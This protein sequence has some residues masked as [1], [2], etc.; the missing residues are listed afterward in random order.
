MEVL[1]GM[2]AADGSQSDFFHHI[3][4]LAG[5]ENNWI[6]H[7]I[8][9]N[10][11][12]PRHR[13]YNM[14]NE[15]DVTWVNTTTTGS[16]AS[17]DDDTGWCLCHLEYDFSTKVMKTEFINL[18]TGHSTGQET[19]SPQATLIAPLEFLKIGPRNIS[20]NIPVYLA[21][22]WVGTA[23]DAWPNGKLNGFG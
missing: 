6:G 15:D 3:T 12:N 4:D 1:V 14:S 8:S 2:T 19:S 9:R 18:E 20:D 22:I 7:S 23:A 5:S 17:P 13:G 21:Q 10:E 16:W 11:G